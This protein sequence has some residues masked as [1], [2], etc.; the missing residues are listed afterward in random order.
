[1]IGAKSRVGRLRLLREAHPSTL[2]IERTAS[3][4][5]FASMSQNFA[6]SG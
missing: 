3:S 1:M 6:K 5:R 4:T 2:P